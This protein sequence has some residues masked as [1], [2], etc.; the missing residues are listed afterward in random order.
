MNSLFTTKLSN[1]LNSNNSVIRGGIFSSNNNNNNGDIFLNMK[2]NQDDEEHC[3][4]V[5]NDEK[6]ELSQIK[7][8]ENESQSGTES[9]FKSRKNSQ[10]NLNIFRDNNVLNEEKKDDEFLKPHDVNINNN[11]N[12]QNNNNI[13]NMI[14]NI[15][16]NNNSYQWDFE[17]EVN[18]KYGLF[19]II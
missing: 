17:D 13:F 9:A 8:A 11:K 12:E 18:Q 5:I 16:N 10:L 7:E 15:N 3:L 4:E 14:N 2:I 19:P 6:N 1:N